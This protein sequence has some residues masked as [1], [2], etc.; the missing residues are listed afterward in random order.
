MKKAEKNMQDV[1]EAKEVLLDA[2]KRRLYDE[3]HS[4]N[5]INSG[6]ANNP[7]GGGGGMGGDMG[8][9]FQ[10]FMGGGMGGGGGFPGGSFGQGG[11]VKFTFRHG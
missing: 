5:D 2:K 7:F 9:I 4:L 10:M 8:D 6:A 1:N 11:N 3:G